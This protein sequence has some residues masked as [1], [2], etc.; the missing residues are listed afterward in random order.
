M[1]IN[2][3]NNLEKNLMVGRG[4]LKKLCVRISAVTQKCILVSTL[5]YIGN[6]AIVVNL[7]GLQKKKKTIFT[8]RL[9]L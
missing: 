5:P 7:Q 2:N 8:N 1:T 9:L 4:L 6:V 3:I